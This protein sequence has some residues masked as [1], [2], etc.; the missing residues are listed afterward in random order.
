MEKDLALRPEAER[1][2]LGEAETDLNMSITQQRFTSQYEQVLATDDWARL[3]GIQLLLR[4]SWEAVDP[5]TDLRL[6]CS[7]SHMPLS[8]VEGNP[9]LLD[10][11]YEPWPGGTQHQLLTVGV[12]IV[13]IVGGRNG[14]IASTGEL[15]LSR[16]RYRSRSFEWLGGH[17]ARPFGIR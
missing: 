14:S 8:L 10:A 15:R 6:S 4:H 1:A 11:K 2:H 7:V 3:F 5:T 13:R 12:E 9:A 17:R 16:F